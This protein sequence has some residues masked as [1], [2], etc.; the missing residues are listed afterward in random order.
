MEPMI[1]PPRSGGYNHPHWDHGAPVAPDGRSG[2]A[3]RAPA[4]MNAPEPAF[5]AA[6][7]RRYDRPGPRYTSYPSAL[8]FDA[9]F[10]EA[11]YREAALRS[12]RA[13]PAAPL[14]VY[15]HVPFCANPCFYCG[16]NRI[17][18]RQRAP[19]QRYTRALEREI[20]LQGRLFGGAR[21][22]E[23]LHFGGGTPTFLE[24]GQLAAVLAAIDRH[25]GLA[26]GE[27]REFSIEVDPRT[28]SAERLRHLTGLGFNRISLGVQDFDPQVQQ[29][30]NRV[31]SPDETLG[32][33][34]EA[35]RAGFGSVS[36]DLIYGLPRQTQASWAHTLDRVL[37]ARPDRIATYSYA[38]LPQRFKAQR[39]IDAA[40][41]PSPQEKLALLAQTIRRFTAA[42]YVYIGMDHFALPGDALAL[43]RRAGTLH[44]NFQGYSTRG[45]LELVGLG[46]TS[47]G[48][49][50]D[51]Y[52]QNARQLDRYYALL[53]EERLPLERG[54][55]LTAEDR[56]RRD[57]IM[58]LM[59]RN[60]FRF[61]EIDA[62]HGVG[63]RAHFADE[64][65]RLRALEA[66]GL[67]EQDAAG[68][69]VLPAGRLLLRAIAMVFDP[70]T[71]AANAEAP[72][73][74]SAVI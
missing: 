1:K 51:T 66:D 69:R 45:G 37:T 10:G 12:T 27:Q 35:R 59:C 41:L 70:Y 68:V 74:H 3:H 58:A 54:L 31:Q 36:V 33:I 57:V 17:I 28:V 61:A 47:I 18:T 16:C 26:R 9:A 7:I 63:S 13:R 20:E 39:H 32:L 72:R 19:A 52:S 29:A 4:P 55:R 24:S 2:G 42:G 11:Q 60:G 73:R 49:L 23:Q 62:R 56:L 6:L 8:Q 22:V 67:V 40:Q 71:A 43:A 34:A 50:D 64:L 38:H 14:S 48:S 53:D 5:D 65:V 21:A 30:V 46:V 44:R 15:V 25:F